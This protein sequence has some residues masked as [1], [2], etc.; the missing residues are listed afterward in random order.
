MLVKED[1]QYFLTCMYFNALPNVSMRDR[2]VVTLKLNVI[3]DIHPRRFDL[4]NLEG[5]QRQ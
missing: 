1:S 5:M 4:D 3:V 2:V